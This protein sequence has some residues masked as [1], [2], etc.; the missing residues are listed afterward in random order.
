MLLL[1]RY[2]ND[3]QG[4][5]DVGV[6]ERILKD[7]RHIFVPSKYMKIYEVYSCILV[8]IPDSEDR[9]QE[10]SQTGW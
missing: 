4:Y 6:E 7:V 10:S 5:N 1:P 9:F 8:S 2:N 3:Q